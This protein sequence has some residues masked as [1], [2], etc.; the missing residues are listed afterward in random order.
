MT[1]SCRVHP[2]RTA[3][4]LRL[5]LDCLEQLPLVALQLIVRRLPGQRN[6]RRALALRATVSEESLKQVAMEHEHA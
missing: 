4:P 1:P 6:I 5:C 2:F 3:G